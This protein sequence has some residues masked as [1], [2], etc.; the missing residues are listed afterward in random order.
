MP[1][2]NK[3]VLNRNSH[4]PRPNNK[5]AR[6]RRQVNNSS[7]NNHKIS[8]LDETLVRCR[9]TLQKN[10]FCS[11]AG[12]PRLS[13]RGCVKTPL[14]E[15]RNLLRDPYRERDSKTNGEIAIERDGKR[16]MVDDRAR[17]AKTIGSRRIRRRERSAYARDV[18]RDVRRQ[19]IL[20]SKKYHSVGA[21]NTFN[22][23]VRNAFFNERWSRTIRIDI[24][25]T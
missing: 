16:D 14:A 6:P 20:P 23:V 19:R 12:W 21:N 3:E 11:S 15:I 10:P 22:S 17:E 25:L 7:S 13:T 5:R 1:P 8:N 4:N 24:I 9:P 2:P 18:Q